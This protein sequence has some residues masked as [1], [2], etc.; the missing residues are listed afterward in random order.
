MRL[1]FIS[2]LTLQKLQTTIWP[3]WSG[4]D[5]PETLSCIETDK[6]TSRSTKLCKDIIRKQNF[7]I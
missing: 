1:N 6:S 7:Q 3:G 4:M 5:T 2:G